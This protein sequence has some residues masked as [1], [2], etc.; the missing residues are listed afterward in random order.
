MKISQL[1]RETVEDTLLLRHPPTPRILARKSKDALRPV[2]AARPV[3]ILS[4]PTTNRAS[5]AV[6]VVPVLAR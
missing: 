2:R 3:S 5:S 6:P 1:S 4:V